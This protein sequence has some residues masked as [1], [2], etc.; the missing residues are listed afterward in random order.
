MHWGRPVN[1]YRRGSFEAA[2]G[3]AQGFDRDII[4]MLRLLAS[5]KTSAQTTGKFGL[6][7]KSVLL[8]SDQPRVLSD[9]HAS[10]PR[11]AHFG[12]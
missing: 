12:G 1:C 7:F 2:R 9:C 4:S 5:D 3:Q 10:S 8:V 6:G 11:G